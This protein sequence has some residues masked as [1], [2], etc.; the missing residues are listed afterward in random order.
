MI[1]EKLPCH[2]CYLLFTSLIYVLVFNIYYPYRNVRMFLRNTTLLIMISII[3]MYKNLELLVAYLVFDIFICSIEQSYIIVFD[4]ICKLILLCQNT[5]EELEIV[6]NMLNCD[7]VRIFIYYVKILNNRNYKVIALFIF[8]LMLY[9]CML[10]FKYRVVALNTL[11]PLY[12]FIGRSLINGYIFYNLFI[13][14]QY[15]LSFL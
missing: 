2:N 8:T 15:N 11:K 12:G 4:R 6:M 7:I 9:N 10:I 3:I 5:K 1:Q 14:V 13:V